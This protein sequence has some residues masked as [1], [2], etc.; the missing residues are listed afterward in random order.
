MA[1]QAQMVQNHVGFPLWGSQDWILDNGIG[2][3]GGLFAQSRLDLQQKQMN[4]TMICTE[5]Q[6]DDSS[7]L[8]LHSSLTNS[9]DLY[10]QIEMQSQ[11]ID[12]YIGL[13]VRIRYHVCR[14]FSFC[15]LFRI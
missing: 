11:E 6:N 15:L 9:G 7:H 10:H 2:G 8:N 13:Q 3:I 12:H 5:M 14:T 4:P 1:I